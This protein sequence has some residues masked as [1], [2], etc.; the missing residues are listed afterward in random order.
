[1][2][3]VRWGFFKQR[4]QERLNFV[5]LVTNTIISYGIYVRYNYMSDGNG[6][7]ERPVISIKYNND[8]KFVVNQIDC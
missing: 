2:L 4:Q 6:T 3:E 5:V 1:M 8:F 7:G